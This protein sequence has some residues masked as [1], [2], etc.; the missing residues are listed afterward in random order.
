MCFVFVF[1]F[2][3]H[4]TLT[5]AFGVSLVAHS[6]GAECERIPGQAH[7][8]HCSSVSHSARETLGADLLLQRS[9]HGVGLSVS[10]HLHCFPFRSVSSY[11]RCTGDRLMREPWRKP[12]SSIC[13]T[14]RSSTTRFSSSKFKILFVLLSLPHL[15]RLHVKISQPSSPTSSKG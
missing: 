10:R 12:S 8:G 15:F 7:Q 14:S 3:S 11:R 13:C 9:L 2:D 1:E 6:H 5:C 4:W